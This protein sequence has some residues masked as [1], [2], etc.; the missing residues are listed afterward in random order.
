MSR[1]I[2]IKKGSRIQY[3]E[4]AEILERTEKEVIYCVFGEEEHRTVSSR[5]FDMWYWDVSNV[6]HKIA[7]EREKILKELDYLNFI[8]KTCQA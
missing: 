6:L 7:I 3:C 1:K 5:K 4:L 8:E 2:V